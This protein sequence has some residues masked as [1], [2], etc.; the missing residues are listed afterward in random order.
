MSVWCPVHPFVKRSL[1]YY[2]TSSQVR[3]QFLLMMMYVITVERV[4]LVV[5]VR[6]VSV[7]LKVRN[8]INGLGGRGWQVSR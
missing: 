7:W 3:Q 4:E 6:H 5:V 2:C 8:A 1:N